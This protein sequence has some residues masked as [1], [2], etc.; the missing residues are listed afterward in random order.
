MGERNFVHGESDVEAIR[1]GLGKTNIESMLY[2]GL[3]F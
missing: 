2:W 3:D 1:Q